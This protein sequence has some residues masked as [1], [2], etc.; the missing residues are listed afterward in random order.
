MIEQLSIEAAAFYPSTLKKVDTADVSLQTF[1]AHK[2]WQFTSGSNTS[3][4][5]A[6]QGVYSSALPALGT[7]L[8]YNDAVNKNGTLQT[9][10]YSSINHLFYRYKSEPSKTFGP[11]DLTRV[12]K[13]LHRTASVLAIPQIR[14]GEGIKP[15]SFTFTSSVSGSYESDRYGNIIDSNIATSAIV[16]G[17][18]FYEGFNE[19]FD[20]TRISYPQWGGI[21]FVGGIPTT[22]VQQRALGLAA[23]FQGAGYIQSELKGAF[24]RNQNFA[25]SFFISGS[26]VSGSNQLIIA[27]ADAATTQRYPFRIDLSGSNQIVAKASAASNA[28]VTA[29]STTAVNTWSHV[30]C[31]KSGSQ[32]QLWVNG[33]LESSANSNILVNPNSPA[34]ASARIDNRDVLKIGG[35]SPNSLNLIGVLDE[36]R[37]FNQA[38]TQ[39]QI[40]ALNNRIEGGTA[41]QTRVVGNV[42][43]KQGL[44]VFSSADYRVADL[45]NTAFT[46]S[47]RSTVSISEVSVIARV[48]AGDFNLST[49]VTLT[50]DDDSTYK[51]FVSSEDFAPYVTQI[52]LYNDMGQLLAVGKLGQPIRKRNDVDM[53]F[54]VRI[55]LDNKILLQGKQ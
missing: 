3:S 14:V 50:E 51:T 5:I 13:I 8:V 49:N 52:G 19:Y 9:I 36:V 18:I 26:N 29:I 55:D 25:V 20:T 35:F 43:G 39:M 1:P 12:S 42:F 41:L 31:Q 4:F 37:I 16:P 6:L 48:D 45:I 34:T 30:V 11:T 10:T 7:E 27:K 28:V 38:L 54:V 53:N 47:Y 24:D 15:A 33:A 22:T 2:K 40:T 23:K 44:V 17:C 46:A 21:S 32:W